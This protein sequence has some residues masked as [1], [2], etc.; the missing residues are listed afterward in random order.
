[1]YV[2][3]AVIYFRITKVL[4]SH[5]KLIKDGIQSQKSE[6]TSVAVQHRLHSSE[7]AVC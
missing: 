5:L 2:D 6:Q 4:Q 1:M 3:L 7:V